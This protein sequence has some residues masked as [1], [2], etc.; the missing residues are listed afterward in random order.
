VNITKRIIKFLDIYY[1]W[2]IVVIALVPMG[3]RLV[4]PTTRRVT[5]AGRC[6]IR[7]NE[8]RSNGCKEG[9]KTRPC[10]WWCLRQ[11]KKGT[12][13]QRRGVFSLDLSREIPRD[14]EAYFTGTCPL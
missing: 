11:A 10:W 2:I 6:T 7:T 5:G 1:G 8:R 13:L 12:F 3:L 4:E 9:V 14:S